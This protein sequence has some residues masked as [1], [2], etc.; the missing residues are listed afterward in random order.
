MTRKE[1][2]H[3]HGK[4]W[5]VHLIKLEQTNIECFLRMTLT[6]NLKMIG[7]T[8]SFKFRVSIHKTNYKL[9]ATKF[10]VGV[11]YYE[12]DKAFL[13]LAWAVKTIPNLKMN[14]RLS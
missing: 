2:W 8:F 12:S 7:F 5:A 10:G 6:R 11:P 14:L 1:N 9:L 3:K 4:K 13:I